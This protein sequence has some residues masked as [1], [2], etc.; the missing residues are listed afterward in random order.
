MAADP[1]ALDDDALGR[2]RAICLALRD[3]EEAELQDRPLFRVGR[4]R[5]ALFNGTD[6]P[7]RPRWDGQGRSLHLLTDPLERDA[8]RQDER[9][10]PSPH[11]GDRG[12]MALRLDGRVDWDEIA[13]LLESAHRQVAP[14]SR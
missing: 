14:R 7:P 3:V 12:W 4:R 2:I 10:A 13:E 1:S 11:H 9:F 5:F 6:A 8:L